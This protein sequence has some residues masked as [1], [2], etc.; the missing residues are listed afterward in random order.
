[1]DNINFF[2]NTERNIV[3][4]YEKY[5]VKYKF[6]NEKGWM[7]DIHHYDIEEN[8]LDLVNYRNEYDMPKFYSTSPMAD[9][10]LKSLLNLAI[11]E[12]LD[13]S[14]YP[15]FDRFINKNYKTPEEKLLIQA[16][17]IISSDERYG[18][19]TM[20]GIYNMLQDKT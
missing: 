12:K 3:E 17:I 16:L 7:S 14:V 20:N 18:N 1:M 8:G 9:K 6:S 4:M 11:D 19:L 2:D 5:G 13:P 10:E 15:P